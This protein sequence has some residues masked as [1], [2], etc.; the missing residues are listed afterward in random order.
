VMQGELELDRI[1]PHQPLAFTVPDHTFE[2]S[3]WRA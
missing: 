3:M 2:G 1:P